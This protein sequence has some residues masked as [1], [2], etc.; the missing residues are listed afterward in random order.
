MATTEPKVALVTGAAKR[1]GA[2]IART[3][4]QAGYFVVIHYR[5]SESEATQ[6]QTQLE[7]A[8]SNS[9]LLV[10]EDLLNIANLPRM[11]SHIL[12][13]TARLDILVNN[14]SSFYPT[15]IGSITEQQFDD[16][17]AQFV[18]EQ[19]PAGYLLIDSQKP[20]DKPRHSN[21]HPRP[22][23][24]RFFEAESCLAQAKLHRFSAGSL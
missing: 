13:Q 3:L 9:T 24:E 12:Q 10:K 14:A 8:R 22:Q 16:L 19:M 5:H 17:I 2:E 4:H 18:A 20:T 15:P 7:L 6:L 23:I 21:Q 11:I 1:I